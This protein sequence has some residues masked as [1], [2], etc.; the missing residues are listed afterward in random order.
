MVHQRV[1]E[2]A[3]MKI[4]NFR[5]HQFFFATKENK[6]NMLMRLH[7]VACNATSNE[8]IKRRN[9]IWSIQQLKNKVKCC[10]PGEIFNRRFCFNH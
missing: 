6:S 3:G 2:Y 5:P 10:K 4:S 1:I 7:E 8:I 9:Y